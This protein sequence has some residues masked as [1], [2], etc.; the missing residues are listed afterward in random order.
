MNK[1]EIKEH[2]SEIIENTQNFI[3]SDQIYNTL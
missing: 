3:T 2:I 1:E